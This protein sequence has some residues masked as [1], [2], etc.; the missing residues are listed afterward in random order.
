MKRFLIFGAITLLI[1]CASS[2]LIDYGNNAEEFYYSENFD[3]SVYRKNGTGTYETVTTTINP[4]VIMPLSMKKLGR[5]PNHY[6]P[7]ATSEIHS[8]IRNLFSVQIMHWYV[9]FYDFRPPINWERSPNYKPFAN[10]GSRLSIADELKVADSSGPNSRFDANSFD[11]RTL[12]LYLKALEM[13]FEGQNALIDYHANECFAGFPPADK[14]RSGLNLPASN[15]TCEALF[16]SLKKYIPVVTGQFNEPTLD[17]IT[18]GPVYADFKLVNGL[19]EFSQIKA[20]FEDSRVSDSDKKQLAKRYLEQLS[21]NAAINYKSFSKT[22]FSPVRLGSDNFTYVVST[23]PKYLYDSDPAR[24]LHFNYFDTAV[25]HDFLQYALL[26]L[27][28]VSPVRYSNHYN[29]FYANMLGGTQYHTVAPQYPD[30]M[31]AR[32]IYPSPLITCL[33][34]RR[35]QSVS[36]PKVSRM[37]YYCERN[38]PTA[39]E[40]IPDPYNKPL[41]EVVDKSEHITGL[42]VHLNTRLSQPRPEDNF[43]TTFYKVNSSAP[44]GVKKALIERQIPNAFVGRVIQVDGTVYGYVHHQGTAYYITLDELTQFLMGYI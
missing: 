19:D 10:Y 28:K 44:N 3:P 12:L 29:L 30:T 6:W 43:A 13:K 35:D 26:G 2:G 1:G 34:N 22:G 31:Y 9:D 27:E 39:W 21:P 11:D 4:N 33:H 16:Q 7:L 36:L 8:D 23:N 32:N 18:F 24:V 25:S 17:N 20:F 37:T 40:L 15:S 14:K 42:T 5:N 38:D 41:P